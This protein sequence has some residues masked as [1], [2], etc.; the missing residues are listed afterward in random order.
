M[1]RNLWMLLVSTLMITCLLASPISYS[2]KKIAVSVAHEVDLSSVERKSG[3]APTSAD[4]I[5]F[6]VYTQYPA[7]FGG[8]GEDKPSDMFWPQKELILYVNATYAGWPE[9]NVNAAFEILYS[10]GSCCSVL[11]N[12]TDACGVAFVR[13]RLPWPCDNSSDLF[14]KWTVIATASIAGEVANDTLVFL[15]DYKVRIWDTTNTDKAEYKHYEEILV[16]LNHGS[17]AM[18]PY[19]ITFTFT[20]IDASGF[21]FG[22][23]YVT[24]GIGGA[25][26]DQYKNRTLQLTLHVVKWARP[27]T[28]EIHI[29][30]LNALPWAGGSSETPEHVLQIYILV[31]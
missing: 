6:D 2:A 4:P 14:G 16:T 23:S 29:G 24:V 27:P 20:A 11:Y 30:G 28:G 7:P 17:L 22:F 8:Q 10:N 15:Y 26:W 21:P 19:E 9:Q 5:F 1:C 3:N 25:A 12:L 31:E 18:Q 13:T